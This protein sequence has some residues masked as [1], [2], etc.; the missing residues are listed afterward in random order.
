MRLEQGWKEM[1]ESC[2]QRQLLAPSATP[3]TGAQ[4]T[5]Q[6]PGPRVLTAT[7]DTHPS[8]AALPLHYLCGNV[9]PAKLMQEKTT[10]E[11][12]IPAQLHPGQYKHRIKVLL[13]P[14]LYLQGK[15]LSLGN[16]K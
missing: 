4:S 6:E 3:D 5:Q 2:A 9:C 7:E 8:R 12:S 13:N 1:C 16:V 11:K 15:K 10:V 14:N